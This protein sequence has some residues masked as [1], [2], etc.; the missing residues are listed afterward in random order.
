MSQIVANPGTGGLA[1]GDPVTGGTP[2][3]VLFINAAG[4]L[5]DSPD[6]TFDSLSSD[7]NVGTS[8][9]NLF[10][11]ATLGSIEATA[12]SKAVLM[13]QD[14]SLEVNGD[15]NNVAFG[16]VLLGVG[17]GR[18]AL[19]NDT[20][21]LVYEN[22]NGLLI[23]ADLSQNIFRA[24][25]QTGTDDVLLDINATTRAIGLTVNDTTNNLIT[26]VTI[27][28]NDEV[29]LVIFNIGTG[30]GAGHFVTNTMGVFSADMGWLDGLG[31]GTN[32]ITATGVAS[33][34]A[35]DGSDVTSLIVN[36]AQSVAKGKLFKIDSN[37]D[38]TI[39]S[40]NTQTNLIEMGDLG[41]NYSGSTLTFNTD[42]NTSEFNLNVKGGAT[43]IVSNFN[44]NPTTGNMLSW[45]ADTTDTITANLAQGDNLLGAGI[46]GNLLAYTDSNT[47]ETINM[48]LGDATAIGGGAFTSAI[49][50][51][52]GDISNNLI[53]DA[54]GSS[55]QYDNIGTTTNASVQT[56]ATYAS[57]RWSDGT[58]ATLMSLDNTRAILEYDNG[59]TATSVNVGDG[60]ITVNS[61]LK[62]QGYTVSTLPTGSV[63]MTAY[64]TD[65]LTPTFGAT[66][67]GG[68]A[69]TIP[70]FYDG[71]AWIV[72]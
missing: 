2:N 8:D 22:S 71:A 43:T 64:V 7:F 18:V 55:F 67:V 56:T 49:Q 37:I 27:D 33:L 48:I 39:A 23:Y 10:V 68:G 57:S 60:V 72:G 62:L 45:D 34:N 16:D 40:F 15:D 9:T 38:R 17:G 14:V 59:T 1:I 41:T 36:Y 44:M 24:G 25:T 46:K 35:T 30:E 19:D 4:D 66:A 47:G 32:V 52:F 3:R 6:F 58:I 42:T 12:D 20:N 11:N 70:V 50:Y 65:A 26:G 28:G 53:I 5:S 21:T 29:N 31:A 69:V 51:V 61:P 63:G 13:S 54:T